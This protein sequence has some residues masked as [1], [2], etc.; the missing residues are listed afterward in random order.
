M[1]DFRS[2]SNLKRSPANHLDTFNEKGMYGRCW[3]ISLLLNRQEFPNFLCF[4]NWK[5]QFKKSNL[6]RFRISEGL[7][8]DGISMALVLDHRSTA[9]SQAV[10]WWII[11]IYVIKAF[12]CHCSK[13]IFIPTKSC[14]KKIII[15]FIPI[16]ILLLAIKS[17]ALK[18]KFVF[19]H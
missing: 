3:T 10:D 15:V 19:K 17:Y 16:L 8:V 9:A 5:F 14:T 4:S 12:A 2:T 7:Y 1:V 11:T 13:N 6:K 18:R